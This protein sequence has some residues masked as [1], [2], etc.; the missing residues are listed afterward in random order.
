MGDKIEIRYRPTLASHQ[1]PRQLEARA[2]DPDAD[3]PTGYTM[4]NGA[5][6]IAART[7]HTWHVDGYRHRVDCV[8]LDD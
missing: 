6:V 8:D 5:M 1:P 7:A 3:P 4:P 2:F